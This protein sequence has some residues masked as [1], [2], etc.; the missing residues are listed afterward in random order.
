MSLTLAIEPL[1]QT[2]KKILECY[3]TPPHIAEVVAESLVEAEAKGVSSHGISRLSSYVSSIKTGTLIPYAEPSVI[4]TSGATTLLDGNF[5][6]GIYIGSKAVELA[7]ERSKEFG[8]SIVLIRHIHHSGMLE[9]ISEQVSRSKQIGII[10]VNAHPVVAAPEG[11]SRIIGT[12]PISISIPRRNGSFNFDF[13]ISKVSFGKVRQ[14]AR[15]GQKLEEGLAVDRFGK[16][17]VEPNE[18]L[19]GALLPFG[20]IKGFGI[21]MVVDILAGILSGSKAG[22][23]VVTWNDLG[24]KW[25]NGMMVMCIDITHFM[26]FNEFVNRVEHYLNSVKEKMP[27]KRI[28][29]EL[30]QDKLRR[31]KSSGICL[32]DDI[33]NELKSL[34]KPW[35]LEFPDRY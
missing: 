32:S 29:G 34:L 18:A 21:G 30:R 8:V 2:I 4:H 13:A 31:A 12:N 35:K 11:G 19:M 6:F 24:L 9:Y 7:L 3:G 14:A 15:E 25:N 5:G 27:R 22:P 20:G 17:T 10:F 1:T 28:P 26:E 23:E 16:P 33:V